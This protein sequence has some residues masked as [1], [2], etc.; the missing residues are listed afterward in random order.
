YTFGLKRGVGAETLSEFFGRLHLETQMGCSP[1]ALRG[2]LQAL[3]HVILETAAAWE[4]EGIAT[5][6]GRPV[7][8]A[9]DETFLGYP[10]KAGHLITS[11]TLHAGLISLPRSRQVPDVR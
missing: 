2:M 5:R 1:S 10:L 6:E 11:A 3:E 7:I 4:H 9:V 8:G